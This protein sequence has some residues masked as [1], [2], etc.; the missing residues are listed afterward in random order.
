MNTTDLKYVMRVMDDHY[1]NLISRDGRQLSDNHEMLE[2]ERKRV[3]GYLQHRLDLFVMVDDEEPITGEYPD[4]KFYPDADGAKM[5]EARLG[6]GHEYHW[7]QPG[8]VLVARSFIAKNIPEIDGHATL[9]VTV[10]R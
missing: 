8:S 10:I 3:M 5:I 6:P 7:S 4:D 2:A 9:M 1:K